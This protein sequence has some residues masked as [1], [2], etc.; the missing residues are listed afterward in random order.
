MSDAIAPARAADTANA[1]GSDHSIEPHDDNTTPAWARLLTRLLDDLIKIPG[2]NQGLGIDA[3]LG[4]VPGVGD[5]VTGLGSMALLLLALK[6]KVPTVVLVKMLGNIGVDVLTGTIPILGD[7]FDVAWRSNRRNLDLIEKHG[8]AKEAA[9]L[10][11]YALVGGGFALAG[12]AIA[13]PFLISA[14]VGYNLVRLLQ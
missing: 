9:G 1:A 2:T 14:A 10:A 5:S 12:L 3:L 8:D 7:I 11:D 6:K 4:L 13:M